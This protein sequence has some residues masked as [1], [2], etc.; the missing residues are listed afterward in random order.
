[1]AKTKPCRGISLYDVEQF[2]RDAG[3]ERINEN[4]VKKLKTALEETAREI[5]ESALVY[6]NYAGR[7][8]L[9]KKEDIMF[10]APSMELVRHRRLSMAR[11]RSSRPGHLQQ[12]H[13]TEV[14]KQEAENSPQI[15][16]VA[17]MIASDLSPK[18]SSMKS[19]STTHM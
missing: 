5:L 8:S 12:P 7:R 10:T 18:A 1:M 15:A 2:F 13:T 19:I 9:V 16:E 14:D 3:A 11:S 6:A 4:A 17:H